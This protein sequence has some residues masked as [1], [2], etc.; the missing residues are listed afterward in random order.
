MIE[1]NLLHGWGLYLIFFGT[2]QLIGRRL[3]KSKEDDVHIYERYDLYYC[4]NPN[5]GQLDEMI[6]GI[7]PAIA[8]MVI[9]EDDTLS[10]FQGPIRYDFTVDQV[11]L[12]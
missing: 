2:N 8:S 6:N 1:L 5:N 9:Y 10:I 11:T 3:A 12:K 4:P 7:K